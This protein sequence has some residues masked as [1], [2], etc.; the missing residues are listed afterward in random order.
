MN[1]Q[2]ISFLALT[3]LSASSL[4]IQTDFQQKVMIESASQTIDMKNNVVT[5]KGDVLVTQGTLKIHADQLQ[6][7]NANTDGEQTLLATGSPASYEQRLENGKLMQAE[8]NTVRYELVSKELTLSGQAKLM[9]QDSVVKG[10]QI[11]YNLEQQVLEANSK[12]DGSERVTTIF[13]P[14]QVQQQMDRD[15]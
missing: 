14:E 7:I 6:I 9:Q 8:A 4:A 13:I 1:I 15:K 2:R 3:L 10:D 12:A 5:Y 11:R